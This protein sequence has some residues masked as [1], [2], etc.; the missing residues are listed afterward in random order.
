MFGI[1]ARWRRD[2]AAG[3]WLNPEDRHE[4]EFDMGFGAQ[5]Q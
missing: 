2:I 5:P 1:V 3:V 4:L